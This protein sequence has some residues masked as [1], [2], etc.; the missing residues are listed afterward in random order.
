MDSALLWFHAT[1]LASV[2]LALGLTMTPLF[3]AF[4]VPMLARLILTLVFAGLAASQAVD[5]QGAVLSASLGHVLSGLGTEVAVGL[6]IAVGVQAAFAAFAVAGR[7]MDVQMGFSLGAVLDPVS[8]GHATVIS[9]GLNMLAVVLFFVSDAHELLLAGVFRTFELL[10]LGQ[11]VAVAGWL[12]V[13]LGAGAMFSLG[14]IMA[15]PVVVAL[16][17]ADVVVG[18]TSRNMPQMNVLF[19]SIPLKL[20]LGLVVMITAIRVIGPVMQHVLTLPLSL[21][22]KVH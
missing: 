16:M 22:D 8:K 15:S 20:L 4:N 1:L 3:T 11:P 9:S 14:F 17:L 6:L 10:P 21:L 5:A 13:A 7:L 12:P 19:L 18:V 2:R